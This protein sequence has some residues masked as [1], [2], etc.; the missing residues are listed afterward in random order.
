MSGNVSTLPYH[1]FASPRSAAQPVH[2]FQP[3][4]STYSLACVLLRCC[5]ALLPASL[6][7]C[8]DD[9]ATCCTSCCFPWL[10]YGFNQEKMDGSSCCGSGVLYFIMV[11]LGCCCLIHAP[12]RTMLRARYG[13]NEDVCNDFC[14]TWCCAFCAIAQEAREMNARDG[15]GKAP[16]QQTMGDNAAYVV[17]SVQPQPHMQPMQPMQLQ[18]QQMQH[19]PSHYPTVQYQATPPTYGE[20]ATTYGHPV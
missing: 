18:T 4:N 8:F 20:S 5:F 16:P 12:R 14:V 6:F 17:P 19:A 13:L 2:T 7:G 9:C 11:S 1:C 10:Q 3:R 15:L